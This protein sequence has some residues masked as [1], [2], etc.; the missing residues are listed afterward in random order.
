[1]HVPGLFWDKAILKLNSMTK[2]EFRIIARI[3]H[4]F[5]CS[6]MLKF[7]KTFGKE[8]ITLEILSHR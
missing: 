8:A 7:T 3:V 6:F 1:M 4:Y 2:S 5:P